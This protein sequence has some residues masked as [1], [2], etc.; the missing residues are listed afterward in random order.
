MNWPTALQRTIDQGYCFWDD[1]IP[2]AVLAM[3]RKERETLDLV[4]GDH[5]THPI[6]KGTMHEV[7][8]LHARSYHDL[9]EVPAAHA[10]ARM[11]SE[12]VGLPDWCPTEAGY[13]LYRGPSDFISPHRD[14][15]SDRLL[16]ATITISGSAVVRILEPLAD[17]DD[18]RN[19]RVV[20]AWV[21]KPGTLLLLRAPGL[22]NGQQVLHEV[23]PPDEGER[24]I[25]NLRTRDT[26]LPPPG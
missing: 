5:V 15:R 26:V 19:V 23:L 20:E 18:Y 1:A 11:L 17:P 10:V 14:R 9:R 16:S 6:A 8:Q 2:E 7:R 12:A 25:L 13:Q 22:G 21:T 24:F 3:L 4:V